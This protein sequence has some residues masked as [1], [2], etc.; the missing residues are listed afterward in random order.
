M[1]PEDGSSG[2][3]DEERPAHDLSAV[4]SRE[5]PRKILLQSGVNCATITAVAGHG[6]QKSLAMANNAQF[7][8]RKR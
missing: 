5:K 7:I 3:A 4:K 2:G 8:A 1:V 6:G